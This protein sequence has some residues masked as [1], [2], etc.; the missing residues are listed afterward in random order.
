MDALSRKIQNNLRYIQER[1][2]I[3]T[4]FYLNK[5]TGISIQRSHEGYNH[6]A[7]WYVKVW[8]KIKKSYE[9]KEREAALQSG[10]F[11]FYESLGDKI[12]EKKG[13]I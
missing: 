4:L 10:Y 6:F 5:Y 3:F 8:G 12:Q 7:Q 9:I 2:G 1:S 11:I 13:E